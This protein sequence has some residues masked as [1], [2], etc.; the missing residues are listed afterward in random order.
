MKSL[1]KSL[2]ELRASGR[3]AFVPYF[4]AGAT[5]DWVRH[6]E[7]A[8]HAGAD[9]IEIGVPFSD[10]MMDGVVI[11]EASLRALAAGTTIDSVC[12]D[13]ADISTSVPL[14]VMTYYNLLLHYGLERVAGK[15]HE[16]GISGAIIPDLAV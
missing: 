11:Q 9:V 1:E 8:A 14:V 5:P 4:V 2:R 6:V 16:S 12:S 10:P 3:K 7:A 13:L 15:L